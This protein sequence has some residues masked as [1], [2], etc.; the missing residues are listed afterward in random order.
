M[1][2][3]MQDIKRRIKSIRSTERITNAMK[4]VSAAK[5][6]RAKALYEHSK[7]YFDRVLESIADSFDD[8]SHLPKEFILGNREIKTSCYIVITSNNGLCG[9]FNGNV[10][11]A[12]EEAIKESHH[13]AELVTIGGRGREFF[14]RRGVDILMQHDD[15]ADTVSYEEIQD[16]ANKLLEK[17]LAGEID[18]IRLIYTTY[19][20]TLSQ[21]V[22]DRHL[23]PIDMEEHQHLSK[24][25]DIEYE[26]SSEDVFQYMTSKYLELALY[27]AVIESAAC[28]HAARRQ[29]MENA[30]DSASEML[31]SLQLEYNRAR[32]AQITD[33]I[34][35]I[36]S[37]SEALS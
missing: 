33:E 19:V 11:R 23:F 20:N 36:V 7:R 31:E 35:E 26:P 4:M 10:I 15:P 14:E 32:Q 27:S 30:S 8:E 2:E 9:S 6:R 1:A 29:A 21:Q 17:Y 25:E 5:L 24:A 3:Q 12:T 16:F 22:V 28:E 18:E 37:G 34:I 13:E